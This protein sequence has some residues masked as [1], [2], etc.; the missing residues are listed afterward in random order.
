MEHL[1]TERRGRKR[2]A[3]VDTVLRDAMAQGVRVC[4][5]A[6]EERSAG[7]KMYFAARA[8]AARDGLPV[9]VQEAGYFETVTLTRVMDPA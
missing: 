2:C 3:A 5:F 1:R 7:R 4:C 8:R 9:R 6:P